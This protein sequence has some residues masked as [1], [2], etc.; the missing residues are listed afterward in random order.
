M[1]VEKYFKLNKERTSHRRIYNK[2]PK[3]ALQNPE[4]AYQSPTE[5][6]KCLRMR[7]IPKKNL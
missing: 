4:E 3:Y 1:E 7:K 5:V 2:T 6:D